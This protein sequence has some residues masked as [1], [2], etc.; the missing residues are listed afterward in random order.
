M[1]LIVLPNPPPRFTF[2]SVFGPSATQEAVYNA[3]AKPL[4]QE[5]LTG[6]NW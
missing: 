5:A 3:T 2:D 4:V 6:Y 1:A